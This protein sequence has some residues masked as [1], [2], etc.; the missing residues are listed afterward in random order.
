MD[1]LRVSL[2]RAEKTR[3][4]GYFKENPDADDRFAA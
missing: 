1:K 3:E 2:I 4:S